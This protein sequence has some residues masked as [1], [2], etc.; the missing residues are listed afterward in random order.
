ML[1]LNPN[2]YQSKSKLLRNMKMEVK[3]AIEL[4][5]KLLKDD[6]AMD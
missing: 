2:L 4:G 6:F 5:S 3:K 1:E